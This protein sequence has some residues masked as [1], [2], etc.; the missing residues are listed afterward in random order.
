MSAC[1]TNLLQLTKQIEDSLR[2]PLKDQNK[3]EEDCED[4]Y[5]SS[6]DGSEM[7]TKFDTDSDWTP[8]SCVLG[9]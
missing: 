6:D 3:K 1:M 2:P 8:E 7:D 5:L 4:L 9:E